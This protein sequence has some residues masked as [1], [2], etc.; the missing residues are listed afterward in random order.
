MFSCLRYSCEQLRLLFEIKV[1]AGA[2]RILP[3]EL[4][5]V[6]IRAEFDS[7]I[8]LHAEIIQAWMML[9]H[10]GGS[11]GVVP[12]PKLTISYEF[13]IFY[14]FFVRYG[15]TCSFPR[16]S[17]RVPGAAVAASSHLGSR[18]FPTQRRRP[19]RRSR[20]HSG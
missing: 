16:E 2:C 8:N 6:V 10:I 20:G 13:T 17:P 15:H 4:E 11:T 3:G 19:A 7:R 12:E 14:N 9:A 1:A 18:K 5:T